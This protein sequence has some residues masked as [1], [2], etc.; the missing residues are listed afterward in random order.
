MVFDE[1]ERTGF[2]PEEFPD[3]HAVRKRKVVVLVS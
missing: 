1:V 3:S 2:G